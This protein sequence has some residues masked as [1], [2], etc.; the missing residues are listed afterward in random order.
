MAATLA[1]F[2]RDAVGS[3]GQ[4]GQLHPTFH[5]RALTFQAVTEKAA[6]RPVAAPLAYCCVA[7]SWNAAHDQQHHVCIDEGLKPTANSP[8]SPVSLMPTNI[9][10]Q[11]N[12][13]AGASPGPANW[14]PLLVS[15]RWGWE[16]I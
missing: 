14:Q 6:R 12:I 8:P 4:T 10:Q 2:P 9:G 16:G 13:S 3:C 15:W 1:G 5:P 11:E 7:S